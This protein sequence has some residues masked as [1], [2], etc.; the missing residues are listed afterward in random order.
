MSSSSKSSNTTVNETSTIDARM[1]A[2]GQAM[3]LR[4]DGGAQIEVTDGGAID[5]AGTLASDALDTAQEFGDLAGRISLDGIELARDSLSQTN[6]AFQQFADKTR[7]DQAQFFDQ[8]I[9]YGIPAIV[10]IFIAR[11]YYK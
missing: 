8:L 1:A 4:A 10:L 11:S 7:S 5:M 9:S 3:V 6:A 2:D